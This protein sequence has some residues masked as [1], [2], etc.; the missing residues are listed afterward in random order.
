MKMSKN[1]KTAE[2]PVVVGASGAVGILPDGYFAEILSES[3]D[4][5]SG[6]VESPSSDTDVV[7]R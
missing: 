7:H 1:E 6:A 2:T 5:N 4:D 3:S